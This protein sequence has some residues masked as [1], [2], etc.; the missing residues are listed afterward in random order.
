M[1]KRKQEFTQS[2][3]KKVKFQED[4]DHEDLEGIN[5]NLTKEKKNNR[6]LKELGTESDESDA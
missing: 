1:E 2:K 6:K 4:S 3:A 5:L